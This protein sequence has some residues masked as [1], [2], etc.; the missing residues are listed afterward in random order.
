MSAIII[1]SIIEK[2]SVL[3]TLP[4]LIDSEGLCFP[5]LKRVLGETRDTELCKKLIKIHLD[6]WIILREDLS[7]L[8]RKRDY[9]FAN[10]PAGK[11]TG[12]WLSALELVTGRRK[13]SKQ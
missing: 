1:S 5:H 7:E 3:K 6:K 12:A 13:N 2:E 8:I 11:E 9:R 4:A 10:E